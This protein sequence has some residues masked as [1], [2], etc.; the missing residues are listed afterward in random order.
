VLFPSVLDVRPGLQE[1]A[2][3]LRDAGHEAVVAD[4]FDGD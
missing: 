2:Q 3:L 1:N 4:P